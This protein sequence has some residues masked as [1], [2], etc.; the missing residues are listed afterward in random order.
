[1]R[2][3]L[4]LIAIIGFN[5]LRA[6]PFADYNVTPVKVPKYTNHQANTIEL[7]MDFG[8]AI[9]LNPE[10]LKTIEGKVYT[11][12]LVYTQFK[13]VSDFDQQALN[14]KRMKVLK[15]KL[16]SKLAKRVNWRAYEQTGAR[17]KVAAEDYFHGFVLHYGNDFGSN[18]WQQ[19]TGDFTKE[20]AVIEVNNDKANRIKYNTGTIIHLPQKAVVYKNGQPVK[21]NYE[22]HYC[23]YRNQSEIALS[24]ITMFYNHEEGTVF[25][26]AGMCKISATKNGKELQLQEPITI[27][28][29]ATSAL[30]NTGFYALDDFGEWGERL[31]G[32][33][34]IGNAVG[35]GSM[36]ISIFG[37][38]SRKTV[39][40]QK[41]ATH[42]DINQGAFE[43]YSRLTLSQKGDFNMLKA[44]LNAAAYEEYS[45]L[46]MGGDSLIVSTQEIGLNN[47]RMYEV[48]LPAKVVIAFVEAVTA[49]PMDELVKEQAMKVTVYKTK[50][51]GT[52]SK[53]TNVTGDEPMPGTPQMVNALQVSGF[54]VYNCDQTFRIQDPVALEPVYVDS[55]T[56]EQLTDLYATCVIDM[57]ING[58]LTYHPNNIVAS[59]TGKTHVLLFTTNNELFLMTNDKLKQVGLNKTKITFPMQNITDQI[60]RPSDL[61]DLLMI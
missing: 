11:I 47:N 37:S 17:T 12:D 9:V 48:L 59:K 41:Y 45:R 35:G 39:Q 50:T 32:V 51:A 53:L 7:K 14:N 40:L 60:K 20:V 55:E 13:T 5:T 10:M 57:R 25:N 52:E 19:N 56:K 44:T 6:T 43:G 29:E 22:L 24:G 27:D 34:F 38:D 3:L 42:S 15:Q 30:E 8:K 49:H 16:G 31:A 1:M 61:Q 33:D 26:S 18:K 58:S 46:K 23:E 54:G 4:L 36:N 28:F 2:Y 21:G